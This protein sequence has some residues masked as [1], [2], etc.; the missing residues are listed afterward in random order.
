MRERRDA[1]LLFFFFADLF[2]SVWMEAA[3][4]CRTMNGRLTQ[5]T[6]DCTTYKRKMQKNVIHTRFLVRANI[7]KSD[8]ER[9]A[10]VIVVTS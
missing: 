8:T 1:F 7:K 4:F 2:G 10:C 6:R 5:V 9:D 3:A